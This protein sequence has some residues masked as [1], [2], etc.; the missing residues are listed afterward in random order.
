MNKWSI[1]FHISR[2]VKHVIYIAE[3]IGILTYSQ[4]KACYTVLIIVHGEARIK[5]VKRGGIACRSST[6]TDIWALMRI[7][8]SNGDEIHN[9]NRHSLADKR[10]VN[11]YREEYPSMCYATCVYIGSIGGL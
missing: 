11:Y 7:Q 9:N 3:P 5:G 6:F 8:Y 10:V 1:K 4:H 2:K